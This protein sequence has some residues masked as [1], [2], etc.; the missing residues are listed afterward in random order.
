MIE[1]NFEMLSDELIEEFEKVLQVN[2]DEV[3]PYNDKLDMEPDWPRYYA[4]EEANAFYLLI[5][6]KDGVIIGYNASYVLRHPHTNAL[7]GQN[8]LIYVVK[9]YR[10][11]KIAL[12]LIYLMDEALKI[13]GC[14]ILSYNVKIDMDFSGML[15]EFGYKEAEK[16]CMK[17]IGD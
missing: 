8:D 17:Y 7:V 1:Y 3:G 9:E 2:W 6:R 15:G 10:R 11:S 4:L 12:K 14:T 16:L 5:A 13:R